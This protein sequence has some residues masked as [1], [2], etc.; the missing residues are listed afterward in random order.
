[1]DDELFKTLMR[2]H[3]E[4]VQP[5]IEEFRA[6]VRSSFKGM[7]TKADMIEH[8]KCIHQRFDRLEEIMRG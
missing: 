6:E 4:V 8:M 5:E 7:V 1:V 2:F 3:R